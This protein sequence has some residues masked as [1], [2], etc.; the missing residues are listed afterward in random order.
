LPSE[1]TLCKDKW[2]GECKK[3]TLEKKHLTKLFFCRV[4][5]R[6]PEKNT[7][8]RLCLPSA[9]KHLAKTFFA[10][11]RVFFFLHSAKKV[12]FLALGSILGKEATLLSV[13]F[14]VLFFVLCKEPVS[15]SILSF[16]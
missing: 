2:F 6:V 5:S 1:K 11:C 7:R 15:G 8:Q 14:R 13:F 9:K 16:F 10:D 3:I 12:F 4:L